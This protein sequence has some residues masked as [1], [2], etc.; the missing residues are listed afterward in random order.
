MTNWD[1]FIANWGSYYNW[2]KLLEIDA[3]HMILNKRYQINLTVYGL[4]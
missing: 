3:Q 1:K 2:G 4:D